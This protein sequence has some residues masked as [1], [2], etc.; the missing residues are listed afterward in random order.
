MTLGWPG[1]LS[2][3]DRAARTVRGLIGTVPF[4]FIVWVMVSQLGRSLGHQPEGV[5]RLVDGLRRLLLPT[6]G[7]H[8]QAQV[9]P[10]VI[11]DAA[12]A[13]VPSRRRRSGP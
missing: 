9:A 10:S 1:E 8:P 4:L 5:D 13:A 7:V 3:P 6:W 11:S 2:G 12:T